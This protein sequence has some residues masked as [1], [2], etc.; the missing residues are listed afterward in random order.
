[1]AHRTSALKWSRSSSA[2]F[3]FGHAPGRHSQRLDGAPAD[4]RVRVERQRHEDCQDALRSRRHLGD[5]LQA[6]LGEQLVKVLFD[7]HVC[8][9]A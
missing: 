4:Q 8:D 3:F 9:Q 1:M 6:P 7:R 5:P 2:M